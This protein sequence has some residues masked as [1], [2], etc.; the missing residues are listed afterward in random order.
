MWR[1]AVGEEHVSLIGIVVVCYPTI[2]V[3][4]VL[5]LLV[6]LKI[7]WP[8]IHFLFQ[9]LMECVNLQCG[10]LVLLLWLLC[11]LFVFVVSPDVVARAVSGGE[12]GASLRNFN[13]V[14]LFQLC[15]QLICNISMIF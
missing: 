3:L 13:S 1:E 4:R 9:L 8:V 10:L 2:L 12:G 14:C 7:C 15:E 11:S 6:S 5:R